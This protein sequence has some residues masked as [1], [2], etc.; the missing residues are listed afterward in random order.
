MVK[1]KLTEIILRILDNELGQTKSLLCMMGAYE[2]LKD[3]LINKDCYHIMTSK[4]AFE[5]MT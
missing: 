5:I 3:L 1:T 4:K 2:V